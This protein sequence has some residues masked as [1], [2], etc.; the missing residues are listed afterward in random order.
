MRFHIREQIADFLEKLDAIEDNEKRCKA[1]IGV[2]LTLRDISRDLQ[3][4][5][6]EAEAL[7]LMNENK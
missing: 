4:D 1:Y 5:I 2:D 6:G 7:I 3:L